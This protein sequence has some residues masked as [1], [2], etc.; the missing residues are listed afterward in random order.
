MGAKDMATQTSPQT[1]VASSGMREV[2]RASELDHPALESVRIVQPD[3]GD[4]RRLM[5][6]I[7]IPETVGPVKFVLDDIKSL[8]MQSLPLVDVVPGTTWRI[9]VVTFPTPEQSV[10]VFAALVM[11]QEGKPLKMLRMLFGVRLNFQGC[12][13]RAPDARSA[14]IWLSHSNTRAM[15]AN[16]IGK[17]APSHLDD[18]SPIEE[19]FM[20]LLVKASAQSYGS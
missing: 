19:L 17:A 1:A 7:K 14:R 6:S 8:G 9:G 2:F 15:I 20:A 16:A 5:V 13:W 11:K 18:E 12:E 10:N 3:T 4:D